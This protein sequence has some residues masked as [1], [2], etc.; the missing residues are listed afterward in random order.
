MKTSQECTL[1]RHWNLIYRYFNTTC[2]Q[3]DDLEFDGEEL[4][5][6]FENEVIER[7]S[8]KDLK[9]IIEGF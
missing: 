4:T 8:A 2:E 5:V 6:W 7:Y 3:Y 9:E 1:C